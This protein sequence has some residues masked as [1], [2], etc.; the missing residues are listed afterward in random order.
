[1]PAADPS[2]DKLR[3]STSFPQSPTLNHQ[4][5][6]TDPQ[7]L[8]VPPPSRDTLYA[9]QT[10]TGEGAIATFVLDG[11][12]C[13]RALAKILRTR[14]SLHAAGKGKLV[15]GRVVDASG[16][17]VDEAVVAPIGP[18][19]SPSGMERVELSCHGGRGA[20]SAV[21]HAL[22]QAGF[23]PGWIG[24]LEVR[25]HR[26]AR[27]SLLAIEA[28]FRLARNLTARQAEFLLGHAALQERWERIGMNAALGARQRTK[29]WRGDLKP[30]IESALAE[31]ESGLRLVR[32]H[33][34]VVTGPVN[35][36]KSTLVNALLR[37]D[38]S[39][40]SETAGT[41]RDHLVR[42]AHLRGLRVL[43]SDTAGLRALGET[44]A[45]GGVE[46]QGQQ[47]AREAV[48]RAD[49]VLYLL[50]GSRAPTEAECDDVEALK[51]RAVPLL[52]VLNKSD[53]GTD[54]EAEGL[55]FALG[56]PGIAVS[57]LTGAG[58]EQ[59]E[60]ALE[61]MLLQGDL[62]EPGAIFTRRQK[63][64]V[65]ALETGL[66]QSLD[67]VQL[68]GHIRALVGTRPNEDE[69]AV[70]FRDAAEGAC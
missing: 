61:R 70:V 65:E 60:S 18:R 33:R 1:M 42:P 32:T 27:L 3:A 67:A 55:A 46:G 6:I 66:E 20:A 39:I 50:D 16:Q 35:A 12:G 26:A 43:L 10:P 34:V 24:E 49:L 44:G 29:G 56:L 38:Q 40:V 30:H 8:R 11:E 28:Q 48:G 57:A 36:G 19:E 41:T 58:L 4:R 5:S 47:R 51:D 31:A 23:R 21:V 62:P 13:F 53:F 37:S 64:C 7:F 52:L 59:M 15:L 68:I 17:L 45:A 54:A 69:L 14:E 63:R 22:E 9:L 25:A 2:F